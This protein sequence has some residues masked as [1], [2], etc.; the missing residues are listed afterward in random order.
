M[1]FFVDC[2][3]IGSHT[4]GPVIGWQTLTPSPS[5]DSAPEWI[6]SKGTGVVYEDSALGA[7]CNEG[8]GEVATEMV[9]EIRSALPDLSLSVRLER[10]EDDGT[11]AIFIYGLKEYDFDLQVKMSEAKGK[12]VAK[13]GEKATRFV[14]VLR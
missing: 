4:T 14:A 1:S 10:F 12:V 8:L 11:T 13:Y 2:V 5:L 7:I 3:E 6:S 9:K